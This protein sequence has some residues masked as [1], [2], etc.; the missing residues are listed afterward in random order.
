MIDVEKKWKFYLFNF[1]RKI[2]SLLLF[3]IYK[4][5]LFELKK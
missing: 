4:E 2:N 3:I 5:N 1:Y